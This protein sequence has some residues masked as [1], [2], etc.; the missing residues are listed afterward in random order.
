MAQDNYFVERINQFHKNVYQKVLRANPY[1][2]VVPMSAFDLNEGRT[3][4][5]RTLTH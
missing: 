1:A 4:I 3:P 2:S 5:V